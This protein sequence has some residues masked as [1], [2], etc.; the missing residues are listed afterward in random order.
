HK[1]CQYTVKRIPETMGP[2]QEY[3]SPSDYSHDYCRGYLR[4]NYKTAVRAFPGP[5]TGFQFGAA[6]ASAAKLMRPFPMDDL[7]SPACSRKKF[8]I[9]KAQQRTQFLKRHSIRT[10][11]IPVN[12]SGIT[13]EAV[14][15]SKVVRTDDIP[16][17]P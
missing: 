17:Q 4:I 7:K 14:Q 1:T 13:I 15:C 10:S 9:Q 11:G 6:S 2:G 16:V 5:F 12:F 3:F 8:L